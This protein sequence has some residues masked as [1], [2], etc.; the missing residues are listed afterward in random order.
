MAEKKPVSKYSRQVTYFRVIIGDLDSDRVWNK[1]DRILGDYVARNCRLRS[2]AYG[3]SDIEAQRNP[4]AKYF[5]KR[6]GTSSRLD[7][8]DLVMILDIE[9]DESIQSLVREFGFRKLM[10]VIGLMEIRRGN[11]VGV[12]KVES[13]LHHQDAI[14]LRPLAERGE[15]SLKW[16]NNGTDV[17]H[18]PIEERQ[19]RH[20]TYQPGVDDLMA[21]NLKLGITEARRRVAKAMG[22]S[23]STVRKYTRDSSKK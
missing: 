1:V 2:D 15:K 12:F 17:A 19:K 21:T 22:V 6:L 14:R 16:S 11:D 18:G 8:S 9:D 13:L 7:D 4:S 10:A 20:A 3:L 23:F 5:W